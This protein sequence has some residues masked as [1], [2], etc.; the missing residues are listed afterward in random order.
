M[1]PVQPWFRRLGAAAGALAAL[2][3]PAR[4]QRADLARRGITFAATASFDGSRLAS[5]GSGGNLFDGQYLLDL[6]AT[7]D[8]KPLL[9][10]SGGTLMVDL[11]SHAGPNVAARQILSIQDPDNM[12]GGA[13]TWIARAWF[14]QDL[15]GRAL[16]RRL[17]LMYVDDQFLTIPY[18]TNFISL[19]FSSDASL[20]TFILPTYPKGA[21]GGDV[22][23]YPT[24]DLYFAGGFFNDHSAELAYDPGGDLAIAE[25]GWTHAWDEM[26]VKL[27]LGAWRDT[28]RLRP[29]AGG[30]D[31]PAAGWYA[32]ASQKLWQP[33]ATPDRGLGM[34][35]QFGEAPPV[36][37]AISGHLAAGLAFTGPS[38]A[39]PHDEIGL[40]FSEGL[41]SPQFGALHGFENE[42]EGYYKIAVVGGLTVQP[43]LEYWQHPSGG[44]TPNALLGMVRVIYA[45]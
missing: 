42:I 20:S 25:A 31:R 3:L 12:D 33:A 32:V 38:A 13:K 43:D 1:W 14:E 2:S 22:F 6:A 9:G 15:A 27:Q 24:A 18:G 28:G 34:F 40:A 36:V 16:R 39:R 19:D 7:L 17:G 30:P 45:F 5:G 23:V 4:T 8:S 21:F 26:P 11:Q 29:F 41:L 10:W 44:A 35:F 37:A